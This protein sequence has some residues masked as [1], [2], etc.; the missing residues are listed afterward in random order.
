MLIVQTDC[1]NPETPDASV[2][3]AAVLKFIEDNDI[4]TLNVAGPR[5]SGWAGGHEFAPRVIGQ[6]IERVAARSFSANA[7]G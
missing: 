3:A 7:D 4:G 1:S 2:A 5:L 6:V